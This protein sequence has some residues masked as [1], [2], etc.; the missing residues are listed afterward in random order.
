MGGK[1]A[2]ILID[3]QRVADLSNNGYTQVYL[4]AGLHQVQQRWTD[5]TLP[6]LLVGPTETI[7]LPLNTQAGDIYYV[8]FS[9]SAT[10]FSYNGTTHTVKL[11]WLL[12]QVSPA[13]GATEISQTRYQ[14]PR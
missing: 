7:E 8:R 10:D 13:F 6:A 1:A 12:Q 5:S 2:Q 14:Q 11:E 3:G 9:T 4:T